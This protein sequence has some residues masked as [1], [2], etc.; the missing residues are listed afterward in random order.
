MT[1]CF[2]SALHHSYGLQEAQRVPLARGQWKCGICGQTVRGSHHLDAHMD[3]EHQDK[4][5]EVRLSM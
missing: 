4:L 3:D 5:I 1:L 2:S